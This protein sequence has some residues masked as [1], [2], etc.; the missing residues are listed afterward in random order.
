MGYAIG[1]S[2]SDPRT[3]EQL[4]ADI[5]ISS[6][7]VTGWRYEYA[8][9][10]GSDGLMDQYLEAQEMLLHLSPEQAQ[11]VCLAQIGK[12]HQLGV[13]YAMLLADGVIDPGEPMPEEYLADAI[14][15]L[16]MHEVGHTLALRH[17]FKASS[18]IPYDK[19]QDK[20]FTRENGVQVS[21]MDYGA[22]NIAV[23]PKQQGYFYNVEVG[24]HD[25]WTIRYAY[26]PIDRQG[27]MGTNG[28][29]AMTPEEELPGLRKIAEEVANPLHTYGADEDNWLGPFAVDPLTNAWELSSDPLAWAR[30]RIAIVNRIQPQLESRLIAEGDGYQRLRGATIGMIFERYIAL[31]PAVKNVG[32]VY[33]NRDH[34]GD[35]AA[36]LPFTPVPAARQREAVQLILTE[37]FAED[38][39]KFDPLVVNKLAP[40][41]WTDWASGSLTPVDFPIHGTVARIQTI[42]MSQML[43]PVRVQ[44]MIDNEMRQ[45]Q[46]S[47]YTA[48]EMFDDVTKATW[49]EL[50]GQRAR[51]V[52]SFRRN[53]QRIHTDTL[54][55]LLLADNPLTPPDARSLARLQLKRIN[56][57]VEGALGRGG[58]DDFTLAHLEE[59][60][61]R[62]ERALNA[63]VSLEIED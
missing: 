63:Q 51:N 57:S 62:T 44:R 8:E 28:D 37:A 21:V 36:R 2:Q 24:A 47:A 3:G 11:Y 45:Q 38:A 15:D 50:G 49:S 43:H 54:I 52:S 12:T 29:Y 18:G 13:Q 46:G 48:A 53:L 39:F 1:P 56:E 17:N 7:F 31:L 30:D 23:D 20:A 26:T 19:L 33:V 55:D 32:G 9:L 35:P 34:K 5:L 4:N 59:T 27:R 60:Q 42:L 10:V 25:V 40:S 6:T 14:R 58:L 22:V 16:I 61:A 41:R